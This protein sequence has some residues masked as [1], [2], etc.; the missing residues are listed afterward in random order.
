[1]ET[2]LKGK[3]AIVTGANRGIGKAIAVRLAA[4]GAQ[5]A[6]CARDANLL[7]Q[8]VKEIENAGG[9]AAAVSL[10]LRMPESP[11][12]AVDLT[13]KTYGRIDIIIN[14]AGATKRGDFLDL[15][16]EERDAFMTQNVGQLYLWGANTFLL[17]HLMRY[18]LFG[19]EREQYSKSIWAA[20][21]SVGRP[22]GGP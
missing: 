5:V 12:R 16:D 8:A 2:R 17:G 9:H 14:N 10:D 13:L 4:E 6:L 3:T 1:M 11:K 21:R 22:A 15:T 18:K 19:V 20:A 7:E